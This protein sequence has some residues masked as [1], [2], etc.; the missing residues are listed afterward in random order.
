MADMQLTP[1]PMTLEE[2]SPLVGLTLEADCAPRAVPMVLIEASPSRH[3]G[4]DD[5]RPFTLIFRSAPNAF[6]VAGTYAMRR[7]GF[8]PALINIAPI[9][10][11]PGAAP[12]R[13]YQAVF[14]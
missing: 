4:L 5:R 12:G 1:R 14:N 3:P 13:Y 9:A 8:G 11:T 7:N 6:L 10:P 2:F